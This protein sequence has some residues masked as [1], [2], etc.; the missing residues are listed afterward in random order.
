MLPVLPR[1]CALQ[2][3]YFHCSRNQ[4]SGVNVRCCSTIY[5]LRGPLSIPAPSLN[6]LVVHGFAAGMLIRRAALAMK[7]DELL[8]SRGPTFSI[9]CLGYSAQLLQDRRSRGEQISMRSMSSCRAGSTTPRMYRFGLSMGAG[10][11]KNSATNPE[12]LQP[13]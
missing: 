13:W 1:R 9:V 12:N 8:E 4:L 11:W 10:I 5:W 6:T 7:G 2:H 3:A